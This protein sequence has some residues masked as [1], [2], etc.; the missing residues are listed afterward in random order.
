MLLSDN[1]LR[2]FKSKKKDF[3]GTYCKRCFF[4]VETGASSW[5]FPSLIPL[6][7]G[8]NLFFYAYSAPN[9]D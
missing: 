7:S 6:E 8:V 4:Q 1:L 3:I 2:E 5:T 9:S